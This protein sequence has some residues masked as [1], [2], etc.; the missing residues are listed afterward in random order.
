MQHGVKMNAA[1]NGGQP[2][3]GYRY[4]GNNNNAYQNNPFAHSSRRASNH[5][6]HANFTNPH[7]NI[8]S[9]YYQHYP[10][11]DRTFS[12]NTHTQQHDMQEDLLFV[13]EDAY[14]PNKIT[15]QMTRTQLGPNGEQQRVTVER[16]FKSEA[17]LNKFLKEFEENLAKNNMKK[18]SKPEPASSAAP[19]E[20]L[21]KSPG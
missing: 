8:Y 21:I 3:G 12:F 1:P 15:V 19:A 9:Q 13:L 17:E 2:N 7:P 20:D 10:H 18:S 5:N 4:Y 14:D 16:D 6:A 11:S